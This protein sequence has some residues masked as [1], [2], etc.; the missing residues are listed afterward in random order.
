MYL[1]GSCELRRR[2]GG[3]WCFQAFSL[4]LMTDSKRICRYKGMNSRD[5]FRN[6][7]QGSLNIF[8]TNIPAGPSFS[9][10][11]GSHLCVPVA[12]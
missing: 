8:F 11:E 3:I 10:F 4:L 12:S 6:S 9:S 1:L 5:Y 2:S 7:Q